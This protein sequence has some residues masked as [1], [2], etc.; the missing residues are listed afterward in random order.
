M[1]T[2]ER[3]ALTESLRGI[4]RGLEKESLRVT[5]RGALAQ[6]PHP[7]GLG[8]ALT[9]HQITTDY[10]EALLEFITAPFAD[11]TALLTQLDD[12]H[13]FT[14]QQL[15]HRQEQLWPSSMPCNIGS[16]A[17]I[18]VAYYGT[19][20]SG[21]MK[22]I[23]RLGLGHRYGRSMQTIAGIHYN[24]SFP[25][26]FWRELQKEKNNQDSLGQFKID[27]YFHLI[28][29][30]RRYFWLLIYLFGAS[31]ALCSSFVKDKK[32]QLMSF[33]FKQSANSDPTLTGS[34]LYLPYATSL[35]MGD[36]GYQSKAQESLVVSYNSLSDYLTTLCNGITQHHPDYQKIGIKNDAGDYLQLNDSLLQ[37]ENEFYSSIRPKCV[38]ERGETALQALRLR[39]IEYV[40]VRCVDLNPYEPLGITAEQ[41][42]VMD[43]FLLFC[44]LSDSPLSTPER[45][46]ED[47]ENQKRVVNFGR[48]PSLQLL[49]DGKSVSLSNWAMTI[50]DGSRTCAAL[51]DK[52]NHTTDFSHAIELQ[53]AKIKNPELTPS[54]ILLREM[55]EKDQSHIDFTLDLAKRH[56]QY[57]TDRPL[58]EKQ[59][60]LYETLATQSL[61][62]QQAL[63]KEQTL[64]FDDYLK[65]YYA[66]YTNCT[67]C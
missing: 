61:L 45:F 44:L 30:F 23:Y 57:F 59:L 28:R 25:D 31:P 32:H 35:R 65:N 51:L 52:A 53:S 54:A 58:S 22:T 46:I 18:P 21:K 33:P 3:I 48:D 39:G 26:T 50:L 34:T 19:S 55:S 5:Q 9:H 20:N 1:Q 4:L 12:I 2:L 16:D 41:I 62:E 24:F 47:R 38:A 27:G 60:A 56:R 64:K 42:R 49:Q 14:Y 36:L 40:E 43:A 7:L 13:R 15:A 67:C 37:I 6:T 8:A 63:E 11:V 29:N 10:S 17:E 66:Q